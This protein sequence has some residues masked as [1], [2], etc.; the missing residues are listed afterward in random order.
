[1]EDNPLRAYFENNPG[2]IIDKWTHYFDVY[3]AHFRELRGKPVR[4]LEIGVAQGGS[5]QMWRNYFGPESVV[6]GVDLNP[7][8]KSLEEDGIRIRIGSQ[9]DRR[10]LASL[11]EEIGELD[12]VID[13][14]GHHMREQIATFE[15]LFP[16]VR[17]GGV[18]LC[19]DCQTSYRLDYGGGVRRPGT[20]VEF[21]KGLV[22]R[23]HAWH[24]EQPALRVDEFT[25][26]ARSVHF[27]DGIVLVRKEAVSP[28]TS[29]KTGVRSLAP[30]AVRPRTGAGLLL[31]LNRVLRALGVRSVGI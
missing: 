6:Y 8:C 20:F 18:Y 9:S 31:G 22:D 29:R 23:L 24:S 26:T 12:V 16:I 28:P 4:I 21:A 11:R 19:E 13:D 2:R 10:F 17:P 25:R 14:G 5:L 27:Y 3:H 30:V 1:M 15:E 7:A